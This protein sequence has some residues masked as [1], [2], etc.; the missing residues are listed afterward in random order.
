[1]DK[2]YGSVLIIWDKL[3]G[4]YQDEHQNQQI[5]YGLVFQPDFFDIFKHHVYYYKKI[6][7]KASSTL[8]WSD[9]TSAIVKGPGWFPGTTGW[10]GDPVKYP[11]PDTQG[12]PKYNPQITSWMKCYVIVHFVLVFIAWNHLS[13]FNMVSLLY[14]TSGLGDL[15]N[16]Y[17]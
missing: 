13:N 4:T 16:S 15:F 6:W 1:M 11:I 8:T 12:R 9:T 10:K 7:D 5:T 3:F 14:T 17:L 2:N